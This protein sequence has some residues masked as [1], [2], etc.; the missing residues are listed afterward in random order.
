[1]ILKGFRFG[2]LLQFAVGPMCLFVFHTATT[3]GFISG[4]SLVF[5]IA[6]ID[7]F[8]IGLSCVGVA[9]IINQKQVKAGVKLAGCLVLVFFGVNTIIGVFGMT[10]LPDI[11]LFS[12]VSSGNLFIKG[13][14]L[15]ASNPLTI[16]FWSGMFSTQMIE[17]NWNK[18]QLTFFAAGCVIA[19]IIF[20]TGVAFLGSMVRGFLPPIVIQLLNVAVGF[21]LIFFGLR[22]FAKE[23]KINND[24][25]D[26]KGHTP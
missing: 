10:L 5:A 15:T 13:M 19:T 7:A 16:I 12:Q 20:L 23:N 4:L 2:L 11:Q 24:E 8:Y 1:M 25:N 9:A 26:E 14:L 21:I 3:Y 22:L 18:R 17:N 6:L